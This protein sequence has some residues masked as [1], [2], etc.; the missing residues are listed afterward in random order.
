MGQRCKDNEG[1]TQDIHTSMGII[2]KMAK[3]E[4]AILHKSPLHLSF[5]W[6]LL[7]LFLQQASC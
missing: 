2:H 1:A 5:I 4:C 7:L 3:Q 6:A